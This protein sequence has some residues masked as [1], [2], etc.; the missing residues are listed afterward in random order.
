MFRGNTLSA[1][2]H[3]AIELRRLE[4][5]LSTPKYLIFRACTKLQFRKGDS[6]FFVQYKQYDKTG[7]VR[8]M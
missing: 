6:M 4:Q 1:V 8:V 5:K 3:L 2:A 7:N